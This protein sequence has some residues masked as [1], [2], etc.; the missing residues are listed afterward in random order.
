MS[1]VVSRKSG[2]ASDKSKIEPNIISTVRLVQLY[3][4][5]QV[6]GVHCSVDDLL[7]G[8]H[9]P[10]AKKQLMRCNLLKD[11]RIGI[12]RQMRA[13]LKNMACFLEQ[14]F[15]VRLNSNVGKVKIFSSLSPLPFF[16]HPTQSPTSC[17]ASS[18][19]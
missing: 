4:G 8:T 14:S 9:Q 10:V 11:A 12:S 1:C 13:R 2:L 17:P 6:H 3:L 7:I 15:N 16:S 5:C 18:V 19:G